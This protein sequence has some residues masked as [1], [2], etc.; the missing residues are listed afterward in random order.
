MHAVLEP[1]PEAWHGVELQDRNEHHPTLLPMLLI[2]P[3]FL[4]PPYIHESHIPSCL[5]HV[6]IF[7]LAGVWQ[8]FLCTETGGGEF[9]SQASRLHCAQLSPINSW[10]ELLWR[11]R[12]WKNTHMPSLKPQGQDFTHGAFDLDQDANVWLSTHLEMKKRR[13][14]ASW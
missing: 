14:L 6:P 1:E 13:A 10:L 7:S 5:C 4:R 11:I 8:A 12:V 2:P 3:L 9:P